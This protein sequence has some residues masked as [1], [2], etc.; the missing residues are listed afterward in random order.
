MNRREFLKKAFQIGGIA[1][2]ISLGAVKEARAWGI[3]PGVAGSSEG[4]VNWDLWPESDQESLNTAYCCMY[5]APNVGD[6][7]IGF[8]G[9]SLLTGLNLV[10]SQV[11]GVAG[12]NAT[13]GGRLIGYNSISD[14]FNTPDGCLDVLNGKSTFTVLIRVNNYGAQVNG[15]NALYA[16]DGAANNKFYFTWGG[17]TISANCTINGV[18]GT[19]QVKA[20]H[21]TIGNDYVLALWGN[22]SHVRM[23][24]AP[25]SPKPTLESDFTDYY[26]THAGAT[27]WPAAVTWTTLSVGAGEG[28]AQYIVIDNTCLF[29]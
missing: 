22:A 4:F 29:G 19:G 7:D 20:S 3:L 8:S 11:G 6:D 24:I 13:E 21:L 2:L 25:A 27:T 9:R 23:G 1:G 18:A 5:D 28:Y 26:E 12:Y 17:A 14:Y 16:S 10:Q 15:Y